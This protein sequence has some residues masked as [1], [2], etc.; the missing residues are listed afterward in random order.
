MRATLALMLSTGAVLGLA[1]FGT[2][3]ADVTHGSVAIAGGE[4][5]STTA[6]AGPAA[7][8]GDP[9]TTLTF[10]VTSGALSLSVPVSANLGSGAPGTDISGAIGPCTVTDDRALLSASWTVTA[11]ETDFANGLNTIPAGDASYSVGSITTTGVITA[12]GTDVTL[13]NS[14]QTVLT[15]SAGVG[16]NTATWDPTITVHVPASAV[17]GL[18]RA[19]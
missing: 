14:A 15:G 1:S 18:S 7:A 11:A 8:P 4:A 6:A 5:V 17:G 3:R 19:P 12:T 10:A 2:A 9:S 13:S 16:D